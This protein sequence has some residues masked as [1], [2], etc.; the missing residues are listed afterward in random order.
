MATT[1][2]LSP[3]YF[4]SYFSLNHVHYESLDA[5]QAHA[6]AM[7]FCL[8][9]WNKIEVGDDNVLDKFVNVGGKMKPTS[10]IADIRNN[11]NQH[12]YFRK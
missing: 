3:L 2:I 12:L 5:S 8:D 6:P 1:R 7:Q 11:L 4:F 9:Q 10:A